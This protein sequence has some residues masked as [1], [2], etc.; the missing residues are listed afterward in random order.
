MGDP[1]PIRNPMGSAVGLEL[2]LPVRS[3]AGLDRLHEC[4]HI[5]VFAPRPEPDLLPSLPPTRNEA[6]CLQPLYVPLV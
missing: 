3:H 5:R 6:M 2:H 1:K 4:D